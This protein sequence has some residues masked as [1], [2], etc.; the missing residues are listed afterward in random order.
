MKG[1]REREDEEGESKKLTRVHPSPF[2]GE[3]RP[4]SDMVGRWKEEGGE[5]RGGDEREGKGG[6]GVDR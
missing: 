3:A 6:E 1:K 5:R 2:E 4:D